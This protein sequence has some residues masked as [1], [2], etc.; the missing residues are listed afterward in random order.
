[1]N[2]KDIDN[3]EGE[4]APPLEYF[5]SIQRAINCGSAWAMQGSYGRSMMAAINAGSCMLGL[6]GCCDYYGN[7]IP[8][9]FEVKDGSKGSRSFVVANCGEDWAQMME[10]V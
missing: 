4:D 8:S 6:K 5:K 9:R 10:E 1:M 7:R 2:L 3:I